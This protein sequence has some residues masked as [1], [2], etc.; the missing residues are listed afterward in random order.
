MAFPTRLA[1]VPC[2]A[3]PLVASHLDSTS[4]SH[5]QPAWG[6]SPLCIAPPLCA[7]QHS[8]A[9]RSST[10]RRSTLP[11]VA[12]LPSKAGGMASRLDAARRIAARRRSI[13]RNGCHRPVPQRV[14]AGFPVRCFAPRLCSPLRAAPHCNVPHLT[15]TLV[16]FTSSHGSR[17]LAVRLPHLVASRLVSTLRTAPLYPAALVTTSLCNSTSPH[18]P[19]KPA[20]G[21]P[22][23]SRRLATQR[24]ASHRYSAQRRSA[25]RE[26]GLWGIPVPRRT[27][28]CDVSRIAAAHFRSTSRPFVIPTGAGRFPQRCPLQC[29]SAPRRTTRLKSVQ[30]NGSLGIRKSAGRHLPAAP[31]NA[32][33]RDSA[34]LRSVQ[35]ASTQ[36]AVRCPKEHWAAFPSRCC[37][38]Q[39][40]V[41]LLALPQ[42][43]VPAL[44]RKG[45]GGLDPNRRTS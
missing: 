8:T 6:G 38:A 3:M 9:R 30:L 21:H 33:L 4:P 41:S 15:A 25:A 32:L 28:C 23:A 11:N 20:V 29:N 17:R 13:L 37:S 19:R 36:R 12:V 16:R 40:Y 43:N 5:A 7:P 34:S 45:S 24:N 27:I 14:R 18:G 2:I 10:Q 35:L 44:S 39:R 1:S 31:C 42:F 22:L 26:G